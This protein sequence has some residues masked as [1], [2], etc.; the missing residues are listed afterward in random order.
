MKKVI[1]KRLVDLNAVDRPMDE[2]QYYQFTN[3]AVIY[4]IFQ[5]KIALHLETICRFI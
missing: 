4:D 2:L 5:V 1:I 3:S